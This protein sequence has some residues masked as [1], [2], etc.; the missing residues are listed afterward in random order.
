MGT[1]NKERILE[2]GKE[3]IAEVLNDNIQ[4]TGMLHGKHLSLEE[5]GKCYYYPENI[6]EEILLKEGY[7]LD[8]L[9][10]YEVGFNF[11]EVL[12]IAIPDAI[13][14]EMKSLHDYVEY[15]H[16]NQ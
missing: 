10:T 14:G 13:M 12:G 11:E 15:I 3:K 4:R 1:I 9:D 5:R 6:K 2:V 7:G 8:S 16:A